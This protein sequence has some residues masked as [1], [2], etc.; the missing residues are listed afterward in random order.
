MKK[1]ISILALIV[2]ISIALMSLTG[3]ANETTPDADT[4]STDPAIETPEAT[5]TDTDNSADNNTDNDTNDDIDADT[6][7]PIDLDDPLEN[8]ETDTPN[9]DDS[10]E[11]IPF[12]FE[13]DGYTI[14]MSQ[15][16]ADVID[17]LGEPLGY[18]VRPSCAFVGDDRIYSYPGVEIF[19][20]PV[21]N[22][23]LVHTIS[24][25]DDSIR[26]P[27]GFYIGIDFQR[28]LDILGDDYSHDSGMFTFTRCI[29]TLEFRV[30]DG[31]VLGITYGIILDFE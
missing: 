10:Q 4:A 30:E 5:P 6:D 2:I 23:N 19:T 20:F 8:D 16:M 15:D 22:I 7:E 25:R 31:I 3:C 18:F 24:I 21:G 28:V 12:Y 11:D 9:V 17:A 1:Y 14:Q 13:F 29:T 27:E 26:T